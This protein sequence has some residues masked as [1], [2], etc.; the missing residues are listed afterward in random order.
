L[1]YIIPTQFTD[2]LSVL[3]DRAPHRP[4]HEIEQVIK[5]EFKV[6]DISELFEYFS[7]EPVASASLAQVHRGT[8]FLYFIFTI[9]FFFGFC[10]ILFLF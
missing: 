2:T 3:Q 1:V 6:L 4:I 5:D 7:D 9:F 8:C 10:H